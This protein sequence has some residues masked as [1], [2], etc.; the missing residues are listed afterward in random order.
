VLTLA[1]M[2]NTSVHAFT[3]GARTNHAGKQRKV[4]SA[5]FQSWLLLFE[6]LLFL[7]L[8]F[9]IEDYNKTMLGNV[10]GYLN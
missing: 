1:V 8:F 5:F 3:E 10:S 6:L 7:Y 9:I 4:T 2:S